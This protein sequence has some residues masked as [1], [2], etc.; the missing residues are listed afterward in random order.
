MLTTRQYLKTLDKP[1]LRKFFKICE[2]SE[3][4]Y[5]LLIYAFVEERM[6]LNTCAK[7][8]IGKTK[9]HSMLNEVLIKVE[10]KIKDLDKLRT[11]Q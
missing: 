10:Y 3:L 9:Y 7:L 4:E 1:T 2:L 8:S 11:F 6:V 5:W